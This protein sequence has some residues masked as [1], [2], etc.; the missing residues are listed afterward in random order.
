MSSPNL[1][2]S[3]LPLFYVK[4]FPYLFAK[5]QTLGKTA[6]SGAVGSPDCNFHCG[7][8]EAARLKAK[9]R[10][11]SAFASECR[12]LAESEGTQ[13][14]DCTVQIFARGMTICVG[15]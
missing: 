9:K 12:W 1:H 15:M 13:W 2:I 14:S 5:M 7:Q 10:S 6:L 11:M 8:E 4:K 3:L